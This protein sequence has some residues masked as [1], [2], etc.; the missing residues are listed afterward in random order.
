MDITLDA[1][2]GEERTASFAIDAVRKLIASYGPPLF[3]S[4]YGWR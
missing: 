1:Y 2:T 3:V 4:G